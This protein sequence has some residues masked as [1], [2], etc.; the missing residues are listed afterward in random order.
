ML[1]H[2]LQPIA[3]LTVLATILTASGA[4]AHRP[5]QAPHQ[6]YKMGDFKLESGEVIKDF[7]ISYVTHGTL[8]AKNRTRS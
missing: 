8:N 7:A 2:R 6:L 4:L 5:D 1:R 3:W